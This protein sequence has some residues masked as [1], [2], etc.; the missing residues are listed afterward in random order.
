MRK[1]EEGNKL[2]RLT[3]PQMSDDLSDRVYGLSSQTWKGYEWK[4]FLLVITRLSGG[5]G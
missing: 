5:Q 3:S 2:H 1:E 4:E